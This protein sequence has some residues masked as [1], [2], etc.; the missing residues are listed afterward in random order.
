MFS[1]RHGLLIKAPIERCFALSTDLG[2][3]ERELG[4][5]PVEGRTGG[6]VTA[7]DTVRWEGMQLGFFNY[8]VSLIEPE[9]WDPPHFFQ[10][11]MVA[12]RFKSFEHDHRL[13]E[14][15]KGTFLDDCV[16]F[17]MPLGR[18]G[19][20]VGRMI[21]VPHILGRMRRRFGLLKHLAETEAWREYLPAFAVEPRDFSSHLTRTEV[22]HESCRPA[23][24]RSAV[25][26]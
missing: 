18:A 9:T 14:T 25:E 1:L 7:G 21:L 10:D 24:V 5:Q 3:V 8:H 22:L 19:E 11:R 20:F 16:R 26:A 4:M 23:R 15:E 2:V 17:T 13:I 6:L 12:G